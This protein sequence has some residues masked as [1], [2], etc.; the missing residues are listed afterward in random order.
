MKLPRIFA[1]I[2][3]TLTTG[4][5]GFCVIQALNWHPRVSGWHPAWWQSGVLAQIGDI[6]SLPAA[7]PDAFIAFG[8]VDRGYKVPNW[9]AYAVFYAS[10]VL[11]L[12]GFAWVSYRI[13]LK[14]VNYYNRPLRIEEED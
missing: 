3:A 10:L 1:P 4:F 13:G 12:V 11:E 8:F 14:F 6:F 2:F 9:V 5:M 7:I